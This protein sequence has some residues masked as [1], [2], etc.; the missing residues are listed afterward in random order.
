MTRTLHKFSCGAAF[1]VTMF[2]LCVASLAQ[3][4][5]PA[6]QRPEREMARLAKAS[7]GVTGV[8]ALHL[9]TGRGVSVIRPCVLVIVTEG[10]TDPDLYAR[11]MN[12]LKP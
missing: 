11:V 10:A 8:T 1:L 5:D 9:E 12:D 6:L 2:S 4:S 3:T 7:G